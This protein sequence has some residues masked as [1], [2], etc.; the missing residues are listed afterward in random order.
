MD[1]TSGE[2]TTTC[3][4]VVG[5]DVGGPSKGFHAVALRDGGYLARFAALEA[6]SMATWCHEISARIIGID[7]PCR[8]STTGRARPAERELAA[9]GICAFAT[10]NR[11]TAENGNFYQWMLNGAE[12]YRLI[13]PHYQLF[14]GRNAALGQVCL[15]TF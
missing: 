8:W 14:D 15:E 7:A 13:E 1:V 5:I 4:V 9:E 10:P 12:L 6:T 11:Q 3:G 2:L